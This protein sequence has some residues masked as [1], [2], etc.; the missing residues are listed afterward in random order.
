LWSD[1]RQRRI[2][3][4]PR[5]WRGQTAANHEGAKKQ[6]LQA[7]RPCIHI[8]HS[9]EDDNGLGQKEGRVSG[10]LS[11]LELGEF[12]GQECAAG[13]A[14]FHSFA[15]AIFTNVIIPFAVTARSG[16]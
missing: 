4:C 14:W 1:G 2:E 9:I 5:P 8:L 12:P 3:C 13:G 7:T 6:N 16:N 15:L 11:W 10:L